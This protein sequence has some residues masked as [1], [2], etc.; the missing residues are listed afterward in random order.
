MDASQIITQCGGTAGF[1]G[2]LG[3]STGVVRMWRHRN[4]I[5]R[6]VWPE[7]IEA[8]PAVTLDALKASETLPA[9]DT[10]ASQ[11]AA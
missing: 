5:P 4:R 1:A 11:E 10:A 6:S 2:A 7:V 9:N 3:V 8:F